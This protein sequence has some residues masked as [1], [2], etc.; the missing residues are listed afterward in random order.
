MKKVLED[1]ANLARVQ[2]LMAAPTLESYVVAGRTEVD[3]W[4]ALHFRHD[5]V[6]PSVPL[7]GDG[8]LPSQS[9]GDVGGDGGEN[10]WCVKA[11]GGN[12]GMDVWV[13]HEGNWRVIVQRL[14]ETEEYVIQVYMSCRSRL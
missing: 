13:M 9:G 12:G 8:A 2:R 4:A 6:K 1:K 5:F 3:R 10:W 7:K 14:H 11:A